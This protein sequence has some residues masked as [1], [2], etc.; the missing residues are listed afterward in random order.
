MVTIQG[1]SI[2]KKIVSFFTS[3]LFF[4]FSTVSPCLS[5]NIGEEREVGE[6]LLY[7]V[8]SAFKLIDDPDITQ[9]L[10][11]L[12]QSVLD[13][14]GIQYFDYHF[15]VINNKEF[16]AFAAPSGLLFF[17]SGVIATMGSENELVSVLAHEIAHIEKRHL[18][19]RIE[20][21]K[22]TSVASL[23]LA[24]AAVAFGGA[25]TPA[26]LTGALATGQSVNL[27]FSRQHEEEADLMAYEWMKR[28]G[29]SPEGQVKMLESM[30]RIAR[31]RSEKLPQYLMTHPN[32]EARLH[33]IQSFMETE[34]K[35]LEALGDN[36][37]NFE[38]LRFKYRI[39]SQVKEAQSFRV[40]LASVISS[41]RSTALEKNMARY[42]LSQLAANEN[43]YDK[44]MQLLEEVIKLY[45]EKNILKVDLGSV[46]FAAGL[47]T[48]AEMTLRKA[49]EQDATDMY[50]TFLLAK[51]L[52]RSE[53]GEEA[54]KYFKEVM[55]EFPEYSKVY[56]ELGQ[57]ASGNGLAGVS[58]LYLG[59]YH[60][61]E[62]K[63]SFAKF[64]LKAASRDKTLPEEMKKECEALLEKIK[65]LKKT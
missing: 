43:D 28:L 52:N 45:P 16:N 35:Q 24:L 53:R 1:R 60:L 4:L 46:E 63:L 7:S 54:E 25:A 56:F 39:L 11:R 64:N 37:D 23:G 26:L 20:K 44:S 22:Y 57:I 13:V 55:Y 34:S 58:N 30:R 15:F 6:K 3:V 14:A 50:A 47:K 18:A 29:R 31:Y 48:K 9:Y 36:T 32:P 38:F 40:F 21:G 17:H 8:R 49:I 33:R 61:Y 65:K 62:G 59:K 10:T 5:F 51:L 12:G 2:K 42:G 41:D 19:S 27:H